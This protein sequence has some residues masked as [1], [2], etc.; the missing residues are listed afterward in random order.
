MRILE[1][2][3][4]FLWL[5]VLALAACTKTEVQYVQVPAEAPPDALNHD[6]PPLD[7]AIFPKV[8]STEFLT[9]NERELL[10]SG[11]NSGNYDA[12]NGRATLEESADAS[13]GG[14]PAPGPNP[15]PEPTPDPTREIVE[16]EP[17]IHI[18]SNL[19]GSILS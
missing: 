13:D 11:T 19:P 15:E 4:T 10:S 9:A 5:G 6:A 7:A 17:F 3:T 14:S 1:N 16:A 18:W 8:G 2:R 12:A